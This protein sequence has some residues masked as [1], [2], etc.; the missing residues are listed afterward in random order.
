MVRRK[1]A[2][3]SSKSSTHKLSKAEKARA[4]AVKKRNKKSPRAKETTNR[5]L[6]SR[7][8]QLILADDKIFA[9]VMFHGNIKWLPEQLAIQALIWSWQESKNVT[10]AFDQTLEI[11]QK[12]ELT[13]VAQTYVGFM[14]AISRYRGI[15]TSRLR[16]HFQGLAEEF[17]GQYFRTDDW[18]LMAFDGSRASAP[19]TGSNEA[20]FCAPNYGHGEK[21]KYGKKKSKTAPRKTAPPEPQ[22]W[23]TLM[24]HMGLR[25]P[26]TWRL[27][28]SNSV[29]RHD[30]QDILE[31][32]EFPEKT[33]FCGDAGF[34]GYPLWSAI[35]NKQ[36]H[37]LVRVGANV[38]LLSEHADTE[39]VGGGIVLCWPKGMM[40]SGEP[41][42]KLRLVRIKVGKTW[43]WLL[44]SV[45][46]QKQLKKKQI[47]RYYALRW[48][49]EVEF[50]G[51]K[52]TIDRCKLRCRNSNRLLAELAWSLFGMAFAELLALQQQVQQKPREGAASYDPKDR[53]LAETLR[54]LR[55]C[56]RNLNDVVGPD[57]NLLAMLAKALV[58]RYHNRTDK[59][60]RYRPK[61]RKAK[62]G[63]PEIR[64][65]TAEERKKLKQIK[66]KK[67]A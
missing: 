52:Q 31:K 23:I 15:I 66:H 4:N 43:M 16:I 29:E 46:S 50:R 8:M 26:W 18:V 39:K 55:K 14:N 56:M 38:K 36:A 63:D 33:L 54:A 59:R 65:L 62:L 13:E 45:L 47:V 6:F 21:A 40:D 9:E 5:A 27:G 41:P 1:Q 7:V 44:T 64:K 42:L 35:I 34:V 2:A 22:V 12:L 60:A 61:K 24:W 51:L 3:S 10:D 32:E 58:Q 30:V 67:A 49:I 48:G 57:E 11:C 20:A 53:S 19:R 28:P 37:F 17:G 25:L